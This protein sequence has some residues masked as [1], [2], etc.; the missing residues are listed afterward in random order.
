MNMKIWYFV[1]RDKCLC[2]Q[3]VS[4]LSIFLTFLV[5]LFLLLLL[6]HRVLYS[7]GFGVTMSPKAILN[8]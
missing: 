3:D 2:C 4:A 1:G 5:D 7:A 8:F 6:L